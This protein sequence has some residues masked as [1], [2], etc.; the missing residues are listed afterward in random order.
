MRNLVVISSLFVGGS[1]FLISC[2]SD[3]QAV[4]RHDEEKRL[5]GT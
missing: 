5:L 2:V 1:L 4:D 3:R